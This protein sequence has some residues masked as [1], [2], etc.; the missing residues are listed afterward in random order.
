MRVN[1][2]TTQAPLATAGRQVEEAKHKASAARQEA[3]VAGELA[4]E[5]RGKLVP[6]RNI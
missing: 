6:E 1:L 2:L 4:A 3:K 5:L